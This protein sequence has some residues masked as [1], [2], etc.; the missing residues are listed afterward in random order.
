[1]TGLTQRPRTL[2]TTLWTVRIRI[3]AFSN[4]PWNA[5]LS[6]RARSIRTGARRK[7]A[8]KPPPI[9]SRAPPR[10]PYISGQRHGL[11][12][13]GGTRPRRRGARRRG[14]GRDRPLGQRQLCAGPLHTADV[15]L[16]FRNRIRYGSWAR[17]RHG[18]VPHSAAPVRARIHPADESALHDARS[19]TTTRAPHPYRH[20]RAPQRPAPGSARSG[21]STGSVGSVLGRPDFTPAHAG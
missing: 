8:R 1:V 9:G 3:C 12:R 10:Q 16:P 19:R 20:G 21:R 18:G 13:S 6:V 2:L 14:R 15:R 7:A 11:T 5:A 4:W 17:R